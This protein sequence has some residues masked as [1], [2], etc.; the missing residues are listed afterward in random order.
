MRVL[1]LLPPRTTLLPV[2]PID[3]EASTREALTSYFRRLCAAN[4]LRVSRVFN[5]LVLPRLTS[6]NHSGKRGNNPAYYYRLVNSTGKPA[7]EWIAALEELTG[8]K[9]LRR[10]TLLDCGRASARVVMLPEH[11][12]KWCPSCY[13][14]TL[15]REDIAYD[16]LAWTVRGLDYCPEHQIPLEITCPHC[17]KGPFLPL[18]GNDVAGFCPH[19]H[20]W[21]GSHTSGPRYRH[22]TDIG[23]SLWTARSIMTILEHRETPSGVHNCSYDQTVN[24]L[25][26]RHFNG[27]AAAFGALLERSKSVVSGWRHGKFLPSWD[28]W[29][30]MSYCFSI[31]LQNLIAGDIDTCVLPLPRA[32]SQPRATVRRKPKRRQWEKI[33]RFLRSVLQDKTPRF[34]SLI[35]TAQHLGIHVRL[36]SQRFPNE[37][38][39]LTKRLAAR[40]RREI[41]HARERDHLILMAAVRE[42]I[43]LLQRH[44]QGPTRQNIERMLSIRKIKLHRNKYYMLPQCLKAIKAESKE[45]GRKRNVA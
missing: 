32:L 31:P 10:L 43:D 5:T 44:G 25:I 27:S 14:D 38:A 12:R 33:G 22:E 24:K 20:K 40:R 13:Q 26:D 30:Q 28:A 3:L 23:Y 37:C 11:H 19:C 17:K 2:E 29:C 21:L 6:V 39:A 35:A 41:S 36:L 16:Q 45:L 18:T 9:G 4:G 42:T 1:D 8:T 7:S 34:D 15:D